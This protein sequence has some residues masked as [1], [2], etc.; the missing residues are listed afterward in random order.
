M[1]QCEIT[2]HIF[3]TEIK[4]Y[5]STRKMTL[6][7]G[8]VDGFFDRGLCC[9]GVF[10]KADLGLV[11]MAAAAAPSALPAPQFSL[12]HLSQIKWD[13]LGFFPPKDIR[14]LRTLTK[15]FVFFVPAW[16]DA[17]ISCFSVMSLIITLCIRRSVR[18][19]EAFTGQI[20]RSL[21]GLR[22]Q[23]RFSP[24]GWRLAGLCTAWVVQLC[25][26]T[27]RVI[28]Q[29]LVWRKNVNYMS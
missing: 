29:A 18:I 9:W 6:I 12:M 1:T 10:C 23:D 17:F 22:C 13:V 8:C 4:K 25:A 11:A 24:V 7:D 15:G 2:W 16:D 14:F 20:C 3:I 27:V 26:V 19:K 21:S 28:V 5:K